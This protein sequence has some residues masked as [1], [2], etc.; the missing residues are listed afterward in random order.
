MDWAKEDLKYIWHPG[1]QMKDYEELP[2]IVAERGRGLWLY[3]VEGKAY[4]D[5]IS[6]WWC[7]LLGHCHPKI[8]A[9]VKAQIDNLEHVIF[10]NFSHK[11]AITLC[12]KLA[13]KVPAGLGKFFFTDNG[14][15]AIEVALKMSFQ[16]H[17]QSG[18]PQ[19]RKFMALTGAYHGE[20]LGALSVSG[21]DLNASDRKSVV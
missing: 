16:Y 15:S 20:T 10:A 17:L 8:N 4:A 21:L 18:R 13:A 5:V 1:S 19:K 2:P 11:A 7:N 6:S 14:S 3:D 9:A 12:E